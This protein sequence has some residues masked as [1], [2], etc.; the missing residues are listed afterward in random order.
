MCGVR[1]ELLLYFFYHFYQVF[2]WIIYWISFLGGA[3]VYKTFKSEARENELHEYKKKQEDLKLEILGKQ[4]QQEEINTDIKELERLEKAYEVLSKIAEAENFDKED[5]IDK[6]PNP[7]LKQQMQHY[8]NKIVAKSTKLL[9]N[10]NFEVVLE[11]SEVIEISNT[12][13]DTYG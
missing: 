8:K 5:S 7:Y 2:D 3:T 11:E 4:L 13:F 12:K 1:C 10:N 6:I 9:D